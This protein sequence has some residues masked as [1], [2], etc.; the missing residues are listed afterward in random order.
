MKDMIAKVREGIKQGKISK[1]LTKAVDNLQKVLDQHNAHF[2]NVRALASKMAPIGQNLRNAFHVGVLPHIGTAVETDGVTA[3]SK[4]AAQLKNPAV[5]SALEKVN[6]FKSKIISATE[7]T[8]HQAFA[9][10]LVGV[11]AAYEGWQA[12]KKSPDKTVGGKLLNAGLAAG[13]S[14][15]LGSNPYVAALDA[16]LPKDYK[17][18]KELGGGAQEISALSEGI[19]TGNDAALQAV[20]QRNL[21]GQN[22]KILQW[23]AEAGEYWAQNGVVGGLKQEGKFVMDGLKSGGKTVVG[24]VVGGAKAVGGF[25]KKGIGSIL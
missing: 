9:D 24:G 1:D 7:F 23:S 14:V 17:I 20:N 22:G 11:G 4:I 15:L 25:I 3:F 6:S 19:F 8:H 16:F 10:T 18:S 12:F 21:N 2:L 5:Q 13:D